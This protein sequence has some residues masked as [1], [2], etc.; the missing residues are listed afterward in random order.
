MKHTTTAVEAIY[1]T[2]GECVPDE[3]VNVLIDQNNSM[4]AW[5]K[6]GNTGI[7]SVSSSNLSQATVGGI[8]MGPSAYSSW[9]VVA[10]NISPDNYFRL[11]AEI[12]SEQFMTNLDK[13]NRR[14]G[15]KL[16]GLTVV[17]PPLVLAVDVADTFVGAPPGMEMVALVSTLLPSLPGLIRNWQKIATNLKKGSINTEQSGPDDLISLMQQELGYTNLKDYATDGLTS[18]YLPPDVLQ[19]ISLDDKGL[20]R[21]FEYFKEA[22]KLKLL[23]RLIEHQVELLHPVVNSE[24]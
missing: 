17:G 24:Q 15:K 18:Q 23:R 14:I 2:T 11:P 8:V 9:K 1:R 10:D 4:I 16:L 12:S 19:L 7:D 21:R 3:P 6:V 22:K 5:G 13:I 20:I